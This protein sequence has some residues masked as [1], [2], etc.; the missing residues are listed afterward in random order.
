MPDPI[1]QTI[2]LE[3]R[4]Q[5]GRQSIAAVGG[6][7]LAI[8]AGEWVAIT[9]PSGCGKSTL[10]NLLGGLD[11][12]TA[13]QV[14]LAGHNLAEY[15][16]EQLARLRR[17]VLGFVFQRHDLFPVLTAQENVEFPLLLGHVS[18]AERG[19]RALSLLRTVGLEAKASHLPD[20]LSGGEQQRVGIARALANSPQVLLA[21]EPTGN[22]DSA[23]AAE[24]MQQMVRLTRGQGL[25]LIVVT[26]DPE[27]AAQADRRLAMKD[28]RLIAD[29]GTRP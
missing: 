7:D 14:R 20:E 3:R 26:H 28:G 11:R 23:T 2:A 4:Y 17:E 29:S 22:L 10:L 5:V 12:P 25:T 13:G 1:L 24:I 18:A 6:L 19:E 15:G 8:A 21:D 9:G 16:E 27:V